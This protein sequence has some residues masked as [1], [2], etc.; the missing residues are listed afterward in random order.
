[1]ATVMDPTSFHTL[2]LLMSII[3]TLDAYLCTFGHTEEESRV[4][5]GMGGSEAQ[6][7]L[8]KALQD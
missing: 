1:M 2:H 3:L 4:G 5:E 8:G 6:K 7:A